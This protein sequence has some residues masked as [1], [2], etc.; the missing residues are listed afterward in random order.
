MKLLDSV[1]RHPVHTFGLGARWLLEEIQAEGVKVQLT[2][3]FLNELEADAHQAAIEEHDGEGASDSY[4]QRLRRE[5][6]ARAQFVRTWT[7]SD[8]PI[9]D[10]TTHDGKLIELA[11]RHS[12]PRGWLLSNPVA[13]EARHP[14][15]TY[16]Y[17]ASVNQPRASTA[18]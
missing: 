3:A 2:R 4:V 12:L 15:P 18:H 10:E 5:L 8:E 7:L 6:S 11:R 1:L 9:S 13:S 14:T 17:W 16:L